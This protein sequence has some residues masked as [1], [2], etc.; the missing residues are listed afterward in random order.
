MS[1]SDRRSRTSPAERCHTGEGLATLSG[2]VFLV[3]DR[4]SIADVSIYA[5]PHVAEEGG[6]DLGR[7]TP[8]RA[9]LARAEEQA[10]YSPITA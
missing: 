3:G 8:T 4:Y 2:R 1:S 6:S 7:Y 9:W 5:Y 10:G